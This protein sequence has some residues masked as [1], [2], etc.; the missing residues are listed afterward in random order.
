MARHP[1]AKGGVL[2]SFADYEVSKELNGNPLFTFVGNI[3]W[4]FPARANYGVGNPDLSRTTGN[5]ASSC[6]MT[7][8]SLRG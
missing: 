5:W 7:G 1:Y 3:S 6:R 4:A 2:L 8:R